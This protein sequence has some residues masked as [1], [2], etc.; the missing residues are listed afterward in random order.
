M[1]PEY[2]VHM[3]K[4]GI[5]DRIPVVIGIVNSNWLVL[6]SMRCKH[7]FTCINAKGEVHSKRIE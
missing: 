4:C 6:C 2:P 7:A 5:E 3:E 1:W